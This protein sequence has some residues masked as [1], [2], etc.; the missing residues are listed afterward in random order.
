MRRD[1]LCVA[2]LYGFHRVIKVIVQH[3]RQRLHGLRRVPLPGQARR[4][5]VQRGCPAINLLFRAQ[6]AVQQVLHVVAAQRRGELDH[7]HDLVWAAARHPE[8]KRLDAVIPVHHLTR[9]LGHA[10]VLAVEY[11]HDTR[12]RHV[13]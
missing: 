5:V 6:T 2:H 7:G 10:G 13:A 4:G 9:V 1:R 12:Q 8:I 3:Q 11:R